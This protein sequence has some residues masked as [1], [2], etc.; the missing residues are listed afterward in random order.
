[1]RLRRRKTERLTRLLVELDRASSA[2]RFRRLPARATRV[3]LLRLS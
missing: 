2:G 3:S 1:M